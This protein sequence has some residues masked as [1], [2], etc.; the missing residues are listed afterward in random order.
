MVDALHE[1]HRVLRPG[2]AVADIRPERDPGNRRRRYIQVECRWNGRQTPVG[3]MYE[4]ATSFPEYAGADRAV[5]RVI[6]GGLF[7]VVRTEVF[8]LRTYVRDMAALDRLLAEEWTETTLPSPARRALAV[9]LRA[10]PGSG[11]V[12]TDMFRLN[13]LRKRAG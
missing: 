6:R 8:L 11:I 10:Y 7:S 9:R 13:V 4:A 1:A 12:A 3:E 2:G 5:A